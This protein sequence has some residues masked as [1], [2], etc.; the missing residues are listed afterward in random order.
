MNY[1][2]QY[3]IT[4]KQAKIISHDKIGRLP[5]CGCEIPVYEYLAQ[6]KNYVTC[7]HYSIPWYTNNLAIVYLVNTSGKFSLRQTISTNPYEMESK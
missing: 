7:V 2:K 1:K 4:L 3:G 5:R 6:V